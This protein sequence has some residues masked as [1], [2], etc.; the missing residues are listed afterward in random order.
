MPFAVEDDVGFS[1]TYM[2]KRETSAT[3]HSLA[4]PIGILQVF[5]EEFSIM[6]MGE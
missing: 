6:G 2:R 1:G 3:E 5:L 4:V